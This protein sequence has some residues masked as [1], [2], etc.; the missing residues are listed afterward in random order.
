MQD[1]AAVGGVNDFPLIRQS[2]TR[3]LPLQGE[4]RDGD[5]LVINLF[6]PIPICHNPSPLSER[7]GK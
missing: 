1:A 2:M 3:L 6:Q 4:G 7:E 5:G